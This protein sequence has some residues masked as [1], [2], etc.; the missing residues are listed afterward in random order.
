L[1]DV[2]FAAVGGSSRDM[3][4]YAKEVAQLGLSAQVKFE[5]YGPQPR[6]SLY[7]K[8]ADILLMPL[9]KTPQQRNSNMSPVKMFEYMASGRPIIASDLPTIR[10]VLNEKNA[11]I[12]PPGDSKALAGAIRALLAEPQRGH[13]LAAKAREEVSAYSWDERAKKVLSF[14]SALC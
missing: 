13:M 4:E 9:P 11:V 5:G 2:L 12:I 10:E 14:M 8:A 6:L 1:P 3:A 7:Q